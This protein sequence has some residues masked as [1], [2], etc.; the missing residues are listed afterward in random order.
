ME[1]KLVERKE[2]IIGGF[3]IETTL[4]N[5]EIDTEKLLNDFYDGKKDFLNKFTKNTQE[6]YAVI[7]YTKLHESY[8]Y[9]IGQKISNKTNELDTKIISEGLYAYTKFPQNY[10]V[11]KAWTDFYQIGIPNVACKPK[12]KDDVAFEYYPNGLNGEYELWSLVE[13]NV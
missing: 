6:Y 2:I 7:W 1:V 8:K 11:I 12:E 13:K 3:S 4:E 10:D 5:N 9:L